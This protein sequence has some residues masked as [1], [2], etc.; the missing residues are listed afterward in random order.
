VAFF[1]FPGQGSQ[2]IGMG[3]EFF[4]GSPVA[5]EI[6]EEAAALGPPGFL[7]QIFSGDQSALN[8]TALAQPALL[9]VEVAIARHLASYGLSPTGCAGHSLGEIPALVVSGALAFA[10]AFRLTQERARLMS[11][12]VPAGGM[13][14]VMGLD[15]DAIEAALPTGV[16][17][18]NFNGPG[19]T[20]ISGTEHGIKEAEELLKAAGAKRVLA[21]SV[22]GPFHSELMRPAAEQFAEYLRDVPLKAPAVA[23]VSS[24]TGGQ[25]IDPEMIRELLARQL[26]SPVRWTQVMAAVSGNVAYEVGPGN[27]L[28]GL[29]KRIEGAPE[30]QTVGTLAEALAVSTAQ[31]QE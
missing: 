15:A 3:S 22:S 4:E 6:F 24:V 20:I 1:L 13:A 19:Q 27:V 17:V 11:E 25:V 12:D 2:K 16:Q 8:H 30:V 21:L 29:A 31:N 28:K 10:H 14:A 23:F 7:D 5:K 26:Y 9:C 18:A